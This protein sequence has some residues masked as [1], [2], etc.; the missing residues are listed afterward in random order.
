MKCAVGGVEEE[1]GGLTLSPT[2]SPLS[3]CKQLLTVNQTE[4]RSL[5]RKEPISAIHQSTRWERENSSQLND[6]HLSRDIRCLWQ[7]TDLLKC[8][9]SYVLYRTTE[10]Y[11][12]SVM[13]T[14]YRNVQRPFDH[15]L[16]LLFFFL[17]NVI[18]TSTV[19]HCSKN[20]YM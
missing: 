9:D 10:T 7:Q 6:S 2:Y 15:R 1:S 12:T 3:F 17:H 13:F 16:P 14:V 19:N 5:L 20:C 8:F 11:C 4:R 18:C